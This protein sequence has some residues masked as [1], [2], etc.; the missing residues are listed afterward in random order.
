MTGE[1]TT[2]INTMINSGNRWKDSQVSEPTSLGDLMLKTPRRRPSLYFEERESDNSTLSTIPIGDSISTIDDEM[3]E[4]LNVFSFI[5]MNGSDLRSRRRTSCGHHLS[6][7]RSDSYLFISQLAVPENKHL[8][9]SIRFASFVDEREYAITIGDNPSCSGPCAL[10]LDW[11]HTETRK[12]TYNDVSLRKNRPLKQLSLF[13]RRRR[14]Q[15]LDRHTEEELHRL[16][17]EIVSHQV[18]SL[19]RELSGLTVGSKERTK[20]PKSRFLP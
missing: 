19:Q 17:L 10:T 18:E 2:S 5:D 1:D 16:E 15:L 13:E 7:H 4:S 12:V 11:D 8:R 6:G 20:W 3:N 14:L 9:R